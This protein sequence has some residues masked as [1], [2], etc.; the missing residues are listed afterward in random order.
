MA[1]VTAP[2]PGGHQLIP[3][4]RLSFGKANP[5]HQAGGLGHGQS[6]SVPGD[7]LPAY[8]MSIA[9]SHMAPMP[10]NQSHD[11]STEGG[12]PLAPRP[13]GQPLPHSGLDLGKASIVSFTA[14]VPSG[15]YFQGTGGGH[16]FV[17][18]VT[19]G[20]PLSSTAGE[21]DEDE[22][23]STQ[24]AVTACNCFLLPFLTCCLTP[25]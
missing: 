21:D 17:P 6:V 22:I 15:P 18:P 13:D 16:E 5:G 25:L 3:R 24:T 11:P 1:S 19:D 14:P 10:S 2:L 9:A 8:D 20:H 7:L 23:P 12:V 4:P